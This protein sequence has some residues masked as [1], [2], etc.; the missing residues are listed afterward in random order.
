MKFLTEQM[1]ENLKD[2]S[3]KKTV[4]RLDMEDKLHD[5]VLYQLEVKKV[6]LLP[7]LS[8]TKLSQIVGTNTTYLSKVVNHR[9][10]SNFR[11]L[12]NRYRV[13]YAIKLMCESADGYEMENII[14]Q[15]GFISRS[16]FYNA[17]LRVEGVPPIR[18]MEKMN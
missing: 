13:A 17:F 11:M 2:S 3:F 14:R 10:G 1:N 4:E 5:S 16:V 8:L 18:Y 9:F 12:L 7:D 6:Y 15:S